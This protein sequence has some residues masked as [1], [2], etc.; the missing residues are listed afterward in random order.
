MDLD[1]A[2]EGVS[3]GHGIIGGCLWMKAGDRVE[4][5]IGPVGML[6]NHVVDEDQLG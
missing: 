3:V 5:A 1:A 4:V 6:S 2:L